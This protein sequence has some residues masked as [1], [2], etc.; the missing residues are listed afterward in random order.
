[1]EITRELSL[2]SLVDRSIEIAKGSNGNNSSNNNT[3]IKEQHDVSK[4]VIHT[5]IPCECLKDCK[6]KNIIPS[7]D[8]YE[9]CIK[10][11]EIDPTLSSAYFQLS[12]LLAKKNDTKNINSKIECFL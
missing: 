2:Q 10:A 5:R 1:M 4:N 3:N 11:L 7:Y 6:N 8:K 12:K 9:L